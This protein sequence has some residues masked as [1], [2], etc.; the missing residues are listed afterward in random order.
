MTVLN[1]IPDGQAPSTTGANSAA[2]SSA[3]GI[4]PKQIT[5]Q[6]FM[7]LLIAQLQNQDPTN[8]V[9]PTQFVTQL[10][11]FTTLDQVSQIN[12]LLQTLVQSAMA[13][14]GTQ[15]TSGAA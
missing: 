5:T 6:D 7:T 13:P 10:A 15:G 3:P 11:Q 8:P 2:Q 12:S 4:Q 14:T 1:S 9:D